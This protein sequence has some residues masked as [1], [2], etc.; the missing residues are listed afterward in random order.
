MEALVCGPQPWRAGLWLRTR[1]FEKFQF[2]MKKNFRTVPGTEISCLTRGWGLAVVVSSP[3]LVACKK[4]Q[5]SFRR[6]D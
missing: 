6:L 3:S 5:P 1:S 2:S 4:R